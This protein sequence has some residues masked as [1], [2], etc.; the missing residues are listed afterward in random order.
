MTVSWQLRCGCV[1]VVDFLMLHVFR[2]FSFSI[3]EA[4]LLCFSALPRFGVR[5]LSRVSS[6]LFCRLS[7]HLSLFTLL[8]VVFLHVVLLFIVL[9]LLYI[10]FV[11]DG[12]LPFPTT[13]HRHSLN[14]IYPVL[15]RF[16]RCHTHLRYP[17]WGCSTPFSPSLLGAV[18]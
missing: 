16:T 6:H 9:F 18:S 12:S 17:Q 13:H 5:T 14:T 11:F 15:R 3:F 8:F 7:F 4:S 2:L 1:V 10:S